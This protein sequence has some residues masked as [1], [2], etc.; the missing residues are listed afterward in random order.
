MSSFIPSLSY[1][2]IL[3]L[4]NSY[5]D[6]FYLLDINRFSS[7][8]CA[9]RESFLRYYPKVQI[10]YSYKTNYSPQICLEVERL[11]GFAEVVS[12]MEYFLACRLGISPKRIVFNGPYK[13]DSAFNHAALSGAILNLDNTL[14]LTRILALSDAYPDSSFNV[15][16]RVNFTLKGEVSRFGFDV[17]NPDDIQLLSRLRQFSNINLVG[18]HCHFPDRDLE[19]FRIRAQKLIN[20]IPRFFDSGSI[21]QYLNIGGGFLVICLIK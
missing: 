9:L 2:Q 16:I 4:S 7:N 17:Q 14:D 20:L 8:F 3:S 12:E 19:S 18:L 15:A 1:Q 5:G 21:P 10:A 6:P 11:G 13:S